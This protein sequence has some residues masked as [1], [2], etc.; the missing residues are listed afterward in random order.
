[1]D[2]QQIRANLRRIMAGE[3]HCNIGGKTIIIPSPSADIH[4]AAEAF[5]QDVADDA[6]FLAPTQEELMDIMLKEELWSA[7]DENRLN[8]LPVSMEA[9][10]IEAWQAYLKFT[11]KRVD[12]CRK[13]LSKLIQEWFTLYAKKHM[14]DHLTHFGLCIIAKNEYVFSKMVPEYTEMSPST[15][16]ILLNSYHSSQLDDIEIRE[17]S[18]AGITRS[19]WNSSRKGL[20][21]DR[22][23]GD[24]SDEQVSLVGWLSLYDNIQENLE[25]PPST[26]IEDD[27]LLDGWLLTQQRS[28][29]KERVEKMGGENLP[30]GGSNK[31]GIQE[32]YIP[33]DTPEDAARINDMNDSQTR[34]QKRQ[35]EKI[36]AMHGNVDETKMPDSQLIMRQQAL[37]EIMERSKKRR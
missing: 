17:L 32:I 5:G 35:R 20:F 36:I 24:W 25:C 22:P 14:F 34:F 30:K 6:K 21:L 33:V 9:I 19:L 12:R 2:N 26:A 11:S 31:P 7:D 1:M 8:Q 18:K 27:I 4:S 37:Q 15:T 10:R 13:Q 23:L 16:R 3:V 28:R 29:E